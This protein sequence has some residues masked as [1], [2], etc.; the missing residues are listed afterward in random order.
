[1]TSPGSGKIGL[2][3][4]LALCATL[5]APYAGCHI[6]TK[7]PSERSKRTEEEGS[8]PNAAR[9]S[10]EREGAPSTSPARESS[11]SSLSEIEEL[12]P[13]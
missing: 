3:I 5:L 2:Y 7:P 12:L 4:I 6:M 9:E 8:R 11:A 13:K 10:E 1:M